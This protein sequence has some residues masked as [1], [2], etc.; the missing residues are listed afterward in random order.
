MGHYSS[1][2]EYSEQRRNIVNVRFDDVSVKRSDLEGK[3]D[4]VVPDTAGCNFVRI[5][6][7]PGRR[8]S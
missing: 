4:R 7:A 5:F 6:A 1:Y 2:T 8:N 3:C